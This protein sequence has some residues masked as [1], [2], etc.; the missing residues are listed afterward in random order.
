MSL[1]TPIGVLLAIAF[2]VPGYSL[3]KAL[4]FSHPYAGMRKLTLHD[5]IML[6]CVAYV[7]ST[8]FL[9]FL[10]KHAPC[11]D[12]LCTP[13]GLSS[14]AGYF[15]SVIVVLLVYPAI[16][17]FTIGKCA[18]CRHVAGFLRKAGVTLLHPAPTAWDYVFA[19]PEALWARVQLKDGEIIDGIFDSNSMAS[20]DKESRDVFL[21][22][23]Y[24]Y[25]D[26]G[27]CQAVPRNRGIY[28]SADAINTVTFFEYS[29]PDQSGEENSEACDD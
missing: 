23:L 6:S 29:E 18:H 13:T 15:F 19:R 17:G 20:S 28:I 27:K 3:R 25:D 14:N 26:T 24:K 7:L 21:E 11:V 4:D 9:Y 10:I 5:Y 22:G 2:I 1:G 16:C 12:Q 8:P